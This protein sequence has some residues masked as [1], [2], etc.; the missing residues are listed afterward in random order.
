M[1]FSEESNRAIFEMGITEEG[2]EDEIDAEEGTARGSTTLGRPIIVGVDRGDWRSTRTPS[3]MERQ[4][5]PLDCD[6]H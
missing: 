6:G 3:E 4:W 1:I 5:R 2:K